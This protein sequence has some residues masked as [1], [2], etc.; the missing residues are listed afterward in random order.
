MNE[1]DLLRSQL[2]RLLDWEDAHVS[3]DTAAAGLSPEHRGRRPDTLP[4][5][6]WELIEHMRL[7]QRDILDF[8]RDPAY[9]ERTWPDEYWPP[10]PAP[11]TPAAW[12]ESIAEFRRDRAALQQLV[13]DTRVDLFARIPHGTG[14]TYLR[15][16]LVVADH[17]SY[18]VGQLVVARQLLG[19][20]PPR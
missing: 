8:C 18:H 16:A 3:F 1:T 9:A 13:A 5:S 14:Q 4:H 17:S 19:S 20:W 12:D 11:P 6:P 7:T 15:E 10:A 2:A